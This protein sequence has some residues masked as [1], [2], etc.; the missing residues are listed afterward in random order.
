[1]DTVTEIDRR[2]KPY[3][4][5]TTGA[6]DKAVEFFEQH[7]ARLVDL[8]NKIDVGFTK[9]AE[10]VKQVDARIVDLANKIYIGRTETT[11]QFKQNAVRFDDL[12]DKLDNLNNTS[13][14][15]QDT[16]A[17]IMGTLRQFDARARNGNLDRG[18][19]KIEYV[20]HLHIRPLEQPRNFPKTIKD[21]WRL[22]NNRKSSGCLCESPC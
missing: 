3:F 15:I 9:T 2:I 7:D 20:P 18:H 19:Q 12:D 17:T 6:F 21:F 14:I 10:Q 8:E 11:V 5:A 13:S 22:K 4:D 16:I 1:M